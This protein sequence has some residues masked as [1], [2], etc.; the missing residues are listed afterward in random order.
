MT[1]TSVTTLASAIALTIALAA[2]LT[3]SACAKQETPPAAEGESEAHASSSAGLPK[4]DIEAGREL[5]NNGVGGGASCVS[6]H[7]ADG[8]APIIDTYPKIGGQYADYIAHALEAYRS[9]ARAG[10][11]ADIMASQAKPL[12]DQQLA[13]IAA[14]FGSVQGKLADMHNAN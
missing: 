4:G 14:Y 2:V 11:N 10:G 13:D 8:N 1:Q 6:C 7:G 5:A 12:S 3:L 9:G